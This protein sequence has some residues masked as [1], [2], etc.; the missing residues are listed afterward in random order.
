MSCFLPSAYSLLLLWWYWLLIWYKVIICHDFQHILFH[1]FLIDK[2]LITF[3]AK[4]ILFWF[5]NDA[6]FCYFVCE[7]ILYS[8]NDPVV[9][10]NYPPHFLVSNRINT[11]IKLKLPLDRYIMFSYNNAVFELLPGTINEIHNLANVLHCAK[12]VKLKVLVQLFNSFV[13][14]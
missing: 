8:T 1:C 4:Q 3:W 7:H 12:V 2:I 6:S 14:L 11:I 5:W 13:S 10:F 9:K